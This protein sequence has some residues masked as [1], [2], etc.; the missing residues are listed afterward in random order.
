M[1]IS[2]SMYGSTSRVTVEAF[3]YSVSSATGC[4]T[5]EVCAVTIKQA[6]GMVHRMF[7]DVADRQVKVFANE[8]A[9]LLAAG[10]SAA[11]LDAPANVSRR[12]ELDLY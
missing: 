9:F 8:R 7:K 1:A 10:Y 2:R 11:Y 5:G 3:P 4:T 6:Y 12:V